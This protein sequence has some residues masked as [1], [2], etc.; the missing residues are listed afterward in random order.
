MV[1]Q[2]HLTLKNSLSVVTVICVVA[3][4]VIPLKYSD[5]LGWLR[6][7]IAI[8]CLAGI[9]VFAVIGQALI[10]SKEDHAAQRRDLLRDERL[11]K[12]ELRL[13]QIGK[14]N[15][16]SQSA[17]AIK[18]VDMQQSS[19]PVAEVEGGIDGEVYRMALAPRS[20]AWELVRDIFKMRGEPEKATVDCDVLVEMYLVNR[21]KTVSRYVRDLT[22]VAEDINGGKITLKRQD[23]LRA[24]DFNDQAFE[25]GLGREGF[26][27]TKD[28]IRQL[29][30]SLPFCL[31]PGQAVEGW[32]RFMA[33]DIN[34]DNIKEKSFQLAV[35]DSLGT[36]YPITK[37]DVAR[38]RKREIGLR[39]LTG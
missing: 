26:F 11:G 29:F 22:L 39:R 31:S 35:V 15:H 1:V 19:A 12:I 25:Y 24:E 20:V 18:P 17:E 38:E 7:Q 32:V 3:L 30:S 14:G 37:A 10:Q 6:W 8:P 36:E 21:S 27:D 13:E 2:L 4:A 9:A 33:K 5:Q 16:A 28:A 34:P 23:D